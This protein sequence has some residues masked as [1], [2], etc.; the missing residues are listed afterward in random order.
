MKFVNNILISHTDLDGYGSQLMSLFR[1]SKSDS[2]D[3]IEKMYNKYKEGNFDIHWINNGE[4]ASFYNFDY[5]E[6][7]AGIR[8]IFN[9]VNPLVTNNVYI[10]DLNLSVDTCNYLDDLKKQGVINHLELID[11]HITGQDS[12][13]RYPEWYNLTVGK[14]ATQL[15]FDKLP[16]M[17]NID[18]IKDLVSV[19]NAADVFDTSDTKVFESGRCLTNIL[20]P[21][22]KSIN[23]RSYSR[24]LIWTYLLLLIHIKEWYRYPGNVV[25]HI[26]DVEDDYGRRRIKMLLNLLNCMFD[27]IP[28][29]IGLLDPNVTIET[30]LHVLYYK[31]QIQTL[32]NL[33]TTASA[34]NTE[35]NVH[36]L[37]VSGFTQS[38]SD[39]SY[40]TLLDRPDIDFIVFLLPNNVVS[41]RSFIEVSED[42]SERVRYDVSKLAAKFGGGGHM[43]AAGCTLKE[44]VT[45]EYIIEKI[46]EYI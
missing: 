43:A 40:Y 4:C 25:D 8:D 23:N 9:M 41:F 35:Q 33:G 46:E 26:L 45:E 17:D 7:D 14:S 21:I 30:P 20:E 32:L 6:V 27:D 19:I 28:Y 5:S 38:I 29:G 2:L 22:L 15:A 24:F 44:E 11:H 13:T 42:R 31:N 16:Q 3:I 18:T 12:A 39:V 10:T 37:V 36:Y 34:H 1:V